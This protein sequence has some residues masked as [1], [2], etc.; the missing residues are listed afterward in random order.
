MIAPGQRERDWR[1]RLGKDGE[2]RTAVGDDSG[3]SG[4]FGDEQATASSS[5]LF[6]DGEL[7]T[8]PDTRKNRASGDEVQRWNTAERR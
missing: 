1:R 2:R 3:S 7:S 8:V 4:F 5:G 6:G